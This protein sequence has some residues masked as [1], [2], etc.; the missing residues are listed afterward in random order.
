VAENGYLVA[1]SFERVE[2]AQ[3]AIEELKRLGFESEN[4][5]YAVQ[6][7]EAQLA[8]SQKV[9]LM[10]SAAIEAQ[11]GLV[12]GTVLGSL[13]GLLA[14]VAVGIVPG[15]GPI[16]GG[17]ILAAVLTGAGLGAATGTVYGVLVGA[18]FGQEEAKVLEHAVSEGRIVVAVRTADRADEARRAL[19]RFGGKLS[20][21]ILAPKAVEDALE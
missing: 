19:M 2:A 5:G 11:R 14:G 9:D 6:G 3:G 13:V 15:I 4:L 8:L 7:E 18:G 10:D 16:I 1:A 12:S 20:S 21:A 17:G